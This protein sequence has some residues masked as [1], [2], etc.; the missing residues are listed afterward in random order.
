MV[1]TGFDDDFK[2]A[3][4]KIKDGLLKI[5][6]KKIIKKIIAV[7]EIGKPMQYGRKDTRE[8]YMQPFRISYKY[9]KE[10]DRIE[11]LEIYHKDEQ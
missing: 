5:K 4:K 11:F 10:E 1:R 7:P 8:V 9:H 2:K 6:V 3:I